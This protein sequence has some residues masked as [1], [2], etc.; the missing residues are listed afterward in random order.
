MPDAL[1]S[2]LAR[3]LKLRE[4]GQAPSAAELCRDRPE[5]LP[6]VEAALAQMARQD[7][8]P[9]TI[10]PAATTDVARSGPQQEEPLTPPA[11]PARATEPP[12]EAPTLVP[13]RDEAGP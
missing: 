2:L 7:E 9:P 6:E 4:E 11:A 13:P 3:W 12:G 10:V 8:S 5:L 1:D